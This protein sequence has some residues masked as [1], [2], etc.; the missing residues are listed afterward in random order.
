MRKKRK[1]NKIHRA[2]NNI[3]LDAANKEKLDRLDELAPVYMSLV[4]FYIDYIFDNNLRDAGKFD[5]VPET[6]TPLSVRWQ[7]CAWQQTVGIMQS[8]FSNGRENRPVLKKTVIQGN[9]N[10]VGIQKS[11][12]DTF[13][14]WLKMATL[15]KG[16]PILVPVKMHKYGKGILETGKLCSGVLLSFENGQWYASF[17]IETENKKPETWENVIGVDL[18]INSLF[19]TAYG[20][21]GQYSDKLRKIVKKS[22]IKRKRK[23]KLNSC[24]KKKGLPTVDLYDRKT[25]AV[26]KNEIGR[27]ANRLINSLPENSVVVLERLSVGTMRFKSRMMNRLL[28]A[29]KIGYA[30]DK[31]KEKLDLNRIRY[32]TVPAAYSSQECSRCGY[33][34]KKNRPAQEIFKCRFCNHSENADVNA[35]RNI[36]KRF[37]DAE[38]KG[39]TDY[40]KLKP[41]LLERFFRRFPDARSVSGG[42][43][44]GATLREIGDLPLTVNQPA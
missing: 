18:G 4:Q 25:E 6:E 20:F 34:D 24:L 27:A 14:F 2:V 32:A 28:K 38:V 26:I 15:E 9:A 36:A 42:L 5:P 17:V 19:T 13:D 16:K 22:D 10:V 41:L 37:G 1:N 31:L 29:S 39:V 44:L 33:V 7:R 8:F 30:S 35:S 12:T 21:F 11:E 23:Q 3:K 43:E 40:R